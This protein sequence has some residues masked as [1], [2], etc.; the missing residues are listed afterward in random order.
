MPRL[1]V[2]ALYWCHNRTGNHFARETL[3]RNEDENVRE[4]ALR[5]FGSRK[6]VKGNR[7]NY[8]ARNI[9]VWTPHVVLI[10]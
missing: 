8:F 9:K 1:F 4:H 7:E 3:G 6:E 5:I 10:R 2:S